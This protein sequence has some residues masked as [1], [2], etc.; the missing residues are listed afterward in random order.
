MITTLLVRAWRWAATYAVAFCETIGRRNDFYWPGRRAGIATAHLVGRCVAR[1][2]D[3][4]W[5]G[6]N[7][8]SPVATL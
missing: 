5:Y 3:G 7:D 2:C 4:V 6:H 1:G 8:A